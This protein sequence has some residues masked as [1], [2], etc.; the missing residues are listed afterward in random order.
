MLDRGGV[1]A[2]DDGNVE[3]VIAEP[4]I[5]DS[6]VAKLE[7]RK[8]VRQVESDETAPPRRV[9]HETEKELSGEDESGSSPCLGAVRLR[10]AYW[11]AMQAV[12]AAEQLWQARMLEDDGR[13]GRCRRRRARVR[14][15][16]R[17]T[18]AP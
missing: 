16:P 13:S 18:R 11:Q 7:T 4:V 17:G 10:I 9:G 5:A 2:P 15:R 14:C 3:P 1:A 6:D 12:E 8:P